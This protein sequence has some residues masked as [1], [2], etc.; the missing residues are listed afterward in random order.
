MVTGTEGPDTWILVVDDEVGM[1]E[2]C[3]RALE[4]E[5]YGVATAA[6]LSAARQCIE[7]KPYDLFLLDIM[8]PD[9]SGLSLLESI[10]ER[11]P[12]AV[13]VVITGFGSVQMAVE[14]VRRGAYDFLSKPFTSDELTMAVNQA[15]ERRRLMQTEARAEE[16]AR[17]KDQ[18]ERL[19]ELKSQF[20]LKVA[21]ELRAPVAAAQSYLNLIGDGYVP[22][23]EMQPTLE[24]VKQRLQEMLDLIGDLLELAALRQAGDQLRA[25]AGPQ[26]MAKVLRELCESLQVLAQD[27]GLSFQIQ[28]RDEPT[29]IANRDHLKVVWTNLISNAIKYTPVGGEIVVSLESNRDQLVGSVADT[30]M[31]ISMAD[32]ENLFQ[33]F[34]RTDQAKASGQIGTG[35]GLAIVKQIV[36]SYGGSISVASDEG[37]GSRFTFSLPLGD[38]GDRTRE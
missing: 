32:Q 6:T 29:I 20:M 33:E 11:D 2:G 24:R 23:D 25:K 19:D 28:I 22:D 36:E 30:G 10:L 15:L 26:N 12:M 21:H 9:G 4:P 34:Y 7:D 31:G 35:L 14:A 3:R 17:E 38:D 1:R 27:K 13:C 16:L 5:G 8:L 37:A 18:L